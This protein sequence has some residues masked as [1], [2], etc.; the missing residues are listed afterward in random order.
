MLSEK[1]GYLVVLIR[2]A[3]AGLLVLIPLFCVPV[4]N[5]GKG[6]R[7]IEEVIGVV[8]AYDVVLPTLC[9]NICKSSLIVRIGAVNEAEPRYI[10]VDLTFRPN[11]FPKEL[12]TGK[13][14]WGFK[15]IKTPSLDK[16]VD[17]FILG[18]NVFGKE[19]KIPRWEVVVGAEDEKMPFGETLHSYSLVKKGF[20]LVPN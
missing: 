3:T 20:K 4:V 1:A 10:R 19:F 18:K 15:L 9:D 14:R 2:C 5:G 11:R 13:K 7:N 6:E 16:R 8:V 12:I 17:E